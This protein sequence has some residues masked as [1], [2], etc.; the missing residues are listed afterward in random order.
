MT[1]ITVPGGLVVDDGRRVVTLDGWPVALSKLPFDLLAKMASDPERAWR[2]EE[3]L[4]D[5]WG[6]QSTNGVTYRALTEC[7][8]AT[9]RALDCRYVFNVR[10]VGYRLLDLDVARRAA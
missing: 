6:Y 3:L 10:G 8:S 2:R 7:A 4:R 1:T 5:V 9:R